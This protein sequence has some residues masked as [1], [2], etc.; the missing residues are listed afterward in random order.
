MEDLTL[1]EQLTHLGLSE[2]EVDTYL[3]ILEHGEATA[4]EIA[5]AT[6]VS[7]RYVYSISESLEERGFVDVDDHVV[8]TKIWARQPEEVVETL[9]DELT[10]MEPALSERYSRTE[11]DVQQFDVVKSRITVVKRIA[12]FISEADSELT[13]SI[14]YEHLSEVADELREAVDRGVL[15]MLLVNDVPSADFDGGELEG[16]ATVVR[17]WEQATPLILTV[18]QQYGVIAPVEMVARS[19][20]NQ[21]AIAFV[22][23]QIVPVLVGSFMGNYWPMATEVHVADPRPLPAEYRSF[24]HAVLDATLHLRDDHPVRVEASV[25]P[26]RSGNGR[27]TVSGKVVDVHQGLVEPATNDFPVENSIVAET[28]DGRITIGGPGSFLEDFEATEVVLTKE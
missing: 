20:T 23:Q 15:A 18:D 2:K 17:T 5:D 25:T 1:S 8:P 9:T 19:N 3:A 24:R 6:G 12:S 16:V 10:A 21:R 26:S 11:R 4:S 7:K 28:D 14:P 13:L 22:Q 27:K